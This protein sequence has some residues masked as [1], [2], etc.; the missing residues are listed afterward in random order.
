MRQP[1][2]ERTQARPDVGA[3]APRHWHDPAQATDRLEL[4]EVLGQT[5]RDALLIRAARA[6]VS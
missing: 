1:A 6:G 4:V 3:A 2:R 5:L